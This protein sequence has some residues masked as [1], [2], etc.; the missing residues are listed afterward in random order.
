[1]IITLLRHGKTEANMLQQFMGSTDVPLSEEG[2]AQARAG[3]IDPSLRLI[4]VTPLKRTQQTAAIL[5]PNARQ[6]VVPGLQ[7]MSFGIFEGRRAQELEDDPVYQAWLKDG[8]H[9]AMPGGESRED[10]ARRVEA[11][12]R[13]LIDERL[14]LGEPRTDILCHGGT[15]MVLMTL[16]VFLDKPYKEWWV[17]NLEGYR[18]TL[19]PDQWHKGERMRQVERIYLGPGDSLP[20]QRPY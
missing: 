15:I 1:M 20:E 12:F 14:A 2:L 19:E 5:Y 10:F 4:H 7:E 3:K 8:D 6:L 17:E 11:A 13:A 18:L 16:F 9:R